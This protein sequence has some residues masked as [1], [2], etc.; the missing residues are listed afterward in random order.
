MACRISELIIDTA[1][2]ERLAAFWSE[3]LDYVELSR[4]SDGS[5]EIGPAGVGFGG[6]QPTLI[7]S[8]N[9]DPRPGKL[10]LHIDV[11]ATDRDQAAELQRLLDLGA[12]P[13]DIGQS[14]TENWHVLIDPEGNEF[15]LLNARLQPL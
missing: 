12:R 3:V 2:P 13:A 15:C 5:I 9:S 11:N 1:D 10:R 6:P 4:E 14:G 8:L 7:F